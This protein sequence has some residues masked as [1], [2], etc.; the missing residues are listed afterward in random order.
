MNRQ[1]LKNLY[2]C[3]NSIARNHERSGKSRENWFYSD[4]EFEQ[5]KKDRQN[6]LL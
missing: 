3:I 1:H 6:T 4:S 2:D 5:I